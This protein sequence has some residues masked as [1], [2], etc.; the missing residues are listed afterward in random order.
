MIASSYKQKGLPIRNWKCSAVYIFIALFKLQIAYPIYDKRHTISKII[1]DTFSFS[2]LFDN[3]IFTD[4]T[5][6]LKKTN[7]QKNTKLT[8]IS[9]QNIF[10]SG[11]FALGKIYF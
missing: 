8:N 11:T 10:S 1:K 3:Y 5:K 7:C 4:L 2:E 9:T 6:N